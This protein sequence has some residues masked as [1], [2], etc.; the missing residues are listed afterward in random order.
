MKLDFQM[1]EWQDK[2]FYINYMLNSS[3]MTDMEE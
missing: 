1:H 3:K 2:I